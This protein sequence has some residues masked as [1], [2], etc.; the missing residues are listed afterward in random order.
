M[1]GKAVRIKS[2]EEVSGIFTL[3]G[4][5]EIVLD[6]RSARMVNIQMR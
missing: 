6:A 1:S 3:V 4:N 2:L 5:H